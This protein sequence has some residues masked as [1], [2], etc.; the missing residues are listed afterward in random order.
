MTEI[1]P[2]FAADVA[3]QFHRMYWAAGGDD[4]DG[5]VAWKRCRW[6][7][8]PLHK[9]PGDVMTYAR[10]IFQLR[11]RWIVELGTL[12][13]GSA[14][15]FADLLELLNKG[16]VITVDVDPPP[17]LPPHPRLRFIRGDCHDPRVAE[18]VHDLV[19]ERR[20][21]VLVTLDA[22]HRAEA[23]RRQ[24][25]LYADLVTRGSYLVVEDTNLNGHPV[26][27]YFGPGPAE[28]LAE[29]LPDHPEFAADPSCEGH[30]IT[31]SPGGWLRRR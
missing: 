12:F 6:R 3:D 24:L 4:R 30:L 23:V 28:A 9:F 20:G 14:L 26:A 18:W 29:W 21:P 31:M 11:P 2:A 1:V 17:C 16:Q 7:D 22:D 19:A 8:V 10:L 15:F 13:G 25:D 27:P 5:D